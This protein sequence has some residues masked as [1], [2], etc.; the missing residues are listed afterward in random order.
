MAHRTKAGA[1]NGV[2]TV[3]VVDR[4][5]EYLLDPLDGEL[6]QTL[7][8]V[9]REGTKYP[10]NIG[11]H[12]GTT[13]QEVLRAL[14]DRAEYVNSQL[15]CAETEAGIGLLKAALFVF[16]A[17]AARYHDRQLTATLDEIV[18]GVGKCPR[19]GHV[20]CASHALPSPQN[21]FGENDER[22]TEVG[23]LSP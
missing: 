10:G 23:R 7:T 5:H 3:I 12:P 6:L 9:K 13:M 11:H 17:R 1:K 15:P 4:G 8:F 22:E 19:C 21:P 2:E 18:K 14:I 20:G 16:E